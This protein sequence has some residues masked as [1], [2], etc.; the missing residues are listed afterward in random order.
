MTFDN[1]YKVG[2]SLKHN[3]PTYVVRN[4]DKQIFEI[5]KAREYCFVFNSRQ[6]G[7]SSLR[8]QAMRKLEALGV[9]CISI[10]LTLLGS[11][12]S[13][14]EWYKGFTCELLNKFEL[15][16]E[17]D[18]DS[19]EK[20][21]RSQTAVQRLN[22]FIESVLLK[23]FCQD[24]V[25]FIDE[26]DFLLGVS[27]KDD[28]F[29]FIRACYNQRAENVEYERLTF[30]LLGVATPTDLIQDKLR[31]PFNISSP[32]ELTGL[33][34][35]EAK[36][37]LIPG[38]EEKVENPEDVLQAVLEWTGGQPFL[39]QKLCSLIVPKAQSSK[40]N[41]R[42][43]VES[44]ILQDWESQDDPQH[45]RTIGGRL[46]S[47][48]HRAIRLLGLYQQILDAARSPFSSVIEENVITAR[49]VAIDAVDEQTLRLSGLLV[50]KDGYLKVY[51]PIYQAV[52]HQDWVKQQLD[53][54]RPYSQAINGWL[55]SDRDSYWL[56]RGKSFDD[57]KA[58]A[59]T[60]LVQKR[61]TIEQLNLT[62]RMHLPTT[63]GVFSAMN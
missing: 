38:L 37:A 17:I 41:I 1:Y 8:V 56:L 4:A 7:K 13:Q 40:P 21:Q 42:E 47:D 35:E 16:N 39:T 44:Y 3:H 61:I 25:I 63:T 48:E 23:K 58:W 51:N 12:V 27:F 33:T 62:L 46:L 36:D 31:T 52:F 20:Q 53:K 55:N 19:W 59:I 28:F 43:L 5:L 15:R 49:E 14:D 29:A 22:H 30:C 6:M 9:K 24:I 34:F 50:K 45:L 32:I 54:L 57:A 2:G 18:F 60:T 10:D 11:N 26:T